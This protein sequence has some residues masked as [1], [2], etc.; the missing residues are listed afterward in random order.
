MILSQVSKKIY[1]FVLLLLALVIY[2]ASGI[3]YSSLKTFSFAMGAEVIQGLAHPDWHYLYDGSGEDLLS[4]L[5]LT[6]G[7]AFLGTFI[8]TI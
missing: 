2:S 7:I 5:L 1:F 6:I 4:L 8:A 3:D